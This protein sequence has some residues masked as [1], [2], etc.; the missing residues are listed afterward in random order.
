M[1]KIIG[2]F[3]LL[4]AGTANAGL[5]ELDWTTTVESFRGSVPGVVGEEITT[6][7]TVDNG[8]SSTLSQDWTVADFVSYRLEGASGWWMESSFIEM[9]TSTGMFSTDALGDVT[10]A[11]NWYGGYHTGATI[12]TSWVGEVDGGWWNNGNNEVA[13][14]QPSA[15]YDCVFAADVDGNLVGS[16]WSASAASVPEPASIALLGLG[17]A[18]L[19]FAKRKKTS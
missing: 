6:T 15:G 11:G 14:T 5:I 3:A 8:G 7:F 19:G 13:C 16:N 4:L 18:G 12:T 10:L 9:P 2:I 17:L 1:K